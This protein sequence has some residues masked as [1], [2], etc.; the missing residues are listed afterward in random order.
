MTTGTL[1]N[2]TA[3]PELR[4][5]EVL[6][7]LSHALDMTEG[8]P[9]GHCIRCAWIGMQVAE[10][11]D[12]PPQMR[13]DLYFT[14][15]M[16]DTGC[17]S[18]AARINEL[19]MMDDLAFKRTFK[20]V[21]GCRQGMPFVLRSTAR[22]AP[23]LTRLKKLRHVIGNRDKIGEELVRNRCGRGAEIA[24]RMRFSER[25]AEAIASLDEHWDG[26]GR[27][28][29]L[30]GEQIPL[31]SRIALMAQV[32]D[33]F[34]LDLGAGAAARE[35]ENRAGV[36]FDPDL[37]R[38]FTTL[39]RDPGFA[40]DLLS[41]ELEQRVFSC[42][43]ALRTAEV[44]ED[45][46]DEISHAFSLVID[47]KSPFTHGHS[48]RVARYTRMIC[49]QLGLAPCHTR[50]MTRA[51]LLH[52]IGKL[53]ISNTI[54]DKPGKLTM[55]EM[56]IVRQ[57]PVWGYDVLSRVGAFRSMAEVILAHH[58]RPDGKG[59]PYGLEGEAL[60]RDMRIMAVADVFDALTADRPYRDAMP[61]ED[62][63]KIMDKMSG[64]GIDPDCYAAL[65]DAITASGWP[66]TSLQ[67]DVEWDSPTQ[68]STKSGQQSA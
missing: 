17:S 66:A 20:R 62:A 23:T 1:L 64:T 30:Q 46:L 15:L 2:G 25:V 26:G 13:T 47:A 38:V 68:V 35:L 40:H 31:L 42:A 7:A 57:H 50:W 22:G 4:L 67:G 55:D 65:Q 27:P 37:V 12:L 34:T 43:H 6:G 5:G 49:E 52:D 60:T 19:Y 44:N 59:Y 18:N 45:Y 54:L 51:A 16:K 56:D 29:G 21:K 9:K 3:G 32:T 10:A 36:W 28:L 58:E 24:R 11:L 48:Q 33:V 8:Q 53:G 39:I 41:P 63:Y 61:L 14:L